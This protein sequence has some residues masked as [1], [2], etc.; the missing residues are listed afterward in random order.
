MY[1]SETK[2][3]PLRMMGPKRCTMDTFEYALTP[4]APR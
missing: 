4:I 2:E 1:E 3:P